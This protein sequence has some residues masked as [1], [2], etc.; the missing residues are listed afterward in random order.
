MPVDPGGDGVTKPARAVVHTDHE[1]AYGVADGLLEVVDDVV[2]AVEQ[3]HQ[4]AAKELVEV[5]PLP[6]DPGTDAVVRGS[7]HD[8]ASFG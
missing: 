2:E 3:H 6:G 8:A 5:V 1:P 7:R 4:V